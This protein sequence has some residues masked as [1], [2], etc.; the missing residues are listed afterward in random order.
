MRLAVLHLVI[1]LSLVAQTPPPSPAQKA[2]REEASERT[3]QLSHPATAISTGAAALGPGGL[4]AGG[5]SLLTG[6]LS[7]EIKARVAGSNWV[8]NM[9]QKYMASAISEHLSKREGEP[10]T[11]KNAKLDDL[12]AFVIEAKGMT[13]AKAEAF[14]KEEPLWKYRKCGY[15]RVVFTNGDQAWGFDTSEPASK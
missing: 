13:L 11:C 15:D 9:T 3:R 7:T 2:A 5:A 8:M 12:I 1:G 14:L 10:Y 6:L 4:V